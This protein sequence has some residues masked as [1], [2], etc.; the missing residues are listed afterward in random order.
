MS[1]SILLLTPERSPAVRVLFFAYAGGNASQIRSW[2]S[3]FPHDVELLGLRYPRAPGNGLRTPQSIASHVCADIVALANV[4]MIFLGYSLG[5]L[6]AYEVSIELS[7]LGFATP[8]HVVVAASRAPHL[9]RKS[10][11]ISGLADAELIEELRH[12][13]GTPEAVLQDKEAIGYLLPI[14]REDL[15]VAEHYY[16]APS[17]PLRCPIT[18]IAGR[19]D[20]LADVPDVAAWSKHT[21]ASFAFHQMDGG[22]FFMHEHAAAMAAI[23][24]RL[25]DLHS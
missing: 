22:H 13:G 17:A 11:A 24:R 19:S 15:A 25:T 2:G 9:P 8:A 16:H 23:I 6:V 21:Q 18:A 4:P 5:A 20:V 10:P 7:R 14:I 3:C 1:K 12:Y